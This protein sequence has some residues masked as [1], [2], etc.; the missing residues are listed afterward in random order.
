[1]DF[2]LLLVMMILER[3]VAFDGAVGRVNNY[4]GLRMAFGQVARG[5]ERLC[6]LLMHTAGAFGTVDFHRPMVVVGNYV[7]DSAHRFFRGFFAYG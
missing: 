4:L 7:I 1:M 6:L 2:F 3:P 5:L